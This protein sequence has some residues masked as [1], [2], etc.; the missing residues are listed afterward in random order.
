[1]N[2]TQA[3]AD[4]LRAVLMGIVMKHRAENQPFRGRDAESDRLNGQA[5]RYDDVAK[6]VLQGMF[7]R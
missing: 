3:E 5:G 4:R 1:M 6:T 7:G 2:G